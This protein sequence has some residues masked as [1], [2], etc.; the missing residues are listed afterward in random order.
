MRNLAWQVLLGVVLFACLEI[1]VRAYIERPNSDFPQAM[2]RFTLAKDQF[3]RIP[4]AYRSTDYNATEEG[5]RERIE[6]GGIFA[7]GGSTT[8]G[9]GVKDRETWPAQMPV[10][11]H[12]LGLPGAGI[13][14]ELGL[15]VDQIGKGRIPRLAIF[16]DGINDPC[17]ADRTFGTRPYFE[18][19]PEALYLA[20]LALTRMLATP[21]AP[22]RS[23]PNY[24]DCAR[25]F[26]A[27]VQSIRAV[28]D[29]Q[30]IV[31]VFILQPPG[32]PPADVARRYDRL[33]D[34]I[35]TLDPSIHDAR[36]ILDGAPLLDWAHPAAEGNRRVAEYIAKLIAASATSSIRPAVTSKPN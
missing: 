7:F 2:E 15:L 4:H 6:G 20:R 35:R 36:G 25:R 34:A 31:T 26:V 30:G 24:E 32:R 27:T 3:R 12:N 8:Y 22:E 9:H 18:L 11:V 13:W 14:D 21:K 29:R 5:F 16:Y 17:G 19:G 28:A 10:K 33:Y 1:A 23:E